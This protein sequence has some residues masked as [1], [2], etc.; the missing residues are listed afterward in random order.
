VSEGLGLDLLRASLELKLP[1]GALELS[2]RPQCVVSDH[3]AVL[4][5]EKDVK[6]KD[7]F[8][9]FASFHRLLFLLLL[10]L[11]LLLPLIR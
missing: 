9:S 5:P 7:G 6:K 11:L 8:L 2:T 10:L 4:F 1:L 3:G